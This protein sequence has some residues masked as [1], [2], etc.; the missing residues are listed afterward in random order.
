MKVL[1]LSLAALLVTVAFQATAA[2]RPTDADLSI[3]A[4]EGYT[5]TAD[6]SDRAMR[7]QAARETLQARAASSPDQETSAAIFFAGGFTPE[8]IGKL[9]TDHGV[10]ISS[11]ELKVVAGPDQRVF[12][13]F[14]GTDDLLVVPGS[15]SERL[16]IAIG[17][18][19]A[20][21]FSLSKVAPADEAARY[22]ELATNRSIRCFRIDVIGEVTSVHAISRNPRVAAAFLQESSDLVD[23]YRAIKRAYDQRHASAP[24]IVKG[25]RPSEDAPLRGYTIVPPTDSPVPKP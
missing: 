21:F 24:T 8:E 18:W 15:L 12:T 9:A 7:I 25:P 16:K 1:V 5:R 22:L 17:H 20:E 3:S 19:R 13:I 14:V 11:A 23:G 6:S 10:E 4:I 2:Q